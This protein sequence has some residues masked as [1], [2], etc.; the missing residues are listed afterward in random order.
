MSNQY[1][2]GG[3][4]GGYL[5]R[6]KLWFF[7]SYSPQYLRRSSDYIFANNER[8]TLDSNTTSQQLFNK[9]SWD[10]H[11]RVRTNFSWLWNPHSQ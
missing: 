5:L 3:S 4:V 8:D 9:V 11:P 1:E 7:T 6:N 10:P 2:P